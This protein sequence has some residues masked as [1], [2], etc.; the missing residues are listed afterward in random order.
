MGKMHTTSLM[1]ILLAYF[2]RYGWIA[3]MTGCILI[4]PAFA[5]YILCVG[6]LIFSIWSFIG[7][8]CKWKHIY[9]SHQ[10]SSHQKMTPNAI[11]W[12]QIEKSEAYGIPLIFFAFGMVG[13][14][15]IFVY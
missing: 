11:H 14:I 9:C 10:N 13:L 3:V 7:Y 5:L 8:K 12:N 6:F 2:H 1:V 15:V 4:W